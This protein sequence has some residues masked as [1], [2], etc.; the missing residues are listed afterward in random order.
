MANLH[1]M[2]LRE[3]LS[4]FGWSVAQGCELCWSRWHGWEWLPSNALICIW[5][6]NG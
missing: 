3:A 6:D 5:I 1:R 4:G 2:G